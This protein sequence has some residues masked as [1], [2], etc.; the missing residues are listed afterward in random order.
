MT[1][2]RDNKLRIALV[3]ERMDAS[4]GGRETST[5]QIARELA[6]RGHEVTIL[7]QSGAPPAEEVRVVCLGQKSRF[8][9]EQLRQFV[10][11]VQR[12][13]VEE[14]YDVVHAM[15]PVVGADV[16][17]P[18]G[19]TVPAQRAASLRRRFSRSWHTGRLK[20]IEG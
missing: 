8:R 14:P 11:A 4:L 17:Q 15:L 7:C 13:I 16:Y 1:E 2:D 9:V 12:H 5:A 6:R 18:R 10:A 20:S 19:G 3:I